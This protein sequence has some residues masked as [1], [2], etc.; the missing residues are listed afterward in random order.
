MWK[1]NGI[2]IIVEKD[3]QDY[4][5]VRIGALDVLGS[6]EPLVHYGG[7]ESYYRDLQF[8]MYDGYDNQFLPLIGSGYFTLSGDQG[9]EGDYVVVSAQPQRLQALNYDTEVYRIN[10]VLRKQ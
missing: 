3:S 4:P 9:V 2:T 5:K 10:V 1:F 7:L 8:V 6:I